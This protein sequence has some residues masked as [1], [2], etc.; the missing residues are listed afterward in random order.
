MLH[1]HCKWTS[2]ILFR[3]RDFSRV[4]N[5]WKYGGFEV[6]CFFWWKHLSWLTSYVELSLQ[7]N[8]A[9]NS[10]H[11]YISWN[12]NFS[13]PTKGEAA[14][15]YLKYFSVIVGKYL[16]F[17]GVHSEI[18]E[19]EEMNKWLQ[20]ALRWEQCINCMEI[21]LLFYAIKK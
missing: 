7:T 8:K 14:K 6:F 13:L 5:T 1:V 17:V 19:K 2:G 3:K 15:Q 20:F 21:V 16:L 12:C 11:Q 18:C 9:N 10:I 4:C